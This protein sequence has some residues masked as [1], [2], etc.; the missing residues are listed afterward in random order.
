MSTADPMMG[1]VGGPMDPKSL[2]MKAQRDTMGMMGMTAGG[3]NPMMLGAEGLGGLALPDM[4]KKKK[5]Q[6]SWGGVG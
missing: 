3:S 6:A 4:M 5:M 2:A 1:G